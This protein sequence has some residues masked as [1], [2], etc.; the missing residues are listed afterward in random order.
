MTSSIVTITS[1]EQYLNLIKNSQEY[2]NITHLNFELSTETPESITKEFTF[3]AHEFHVN[4]DNTT[5]MTTTKTF[6]PKSEY[7]K[8]FSHTFNI[9]KNVIKPIDIVIP[10]NI[11]VLDLSNTNFLISNL[12]VSKLPQ[13]CT[14]IIL[15]NS[16]YKRIIGKNNSIMSIYIDNCKYIYEIEEINDHFLISY[17]DNAEMTRVIYHQKHLN[18]LQQ[19]KFYNDI[20]VLFLQSNNIKTFPNILPTNLNELYINST[21]I[22]SITTSFPQSLTTLYITQTPIT[23]LG[24]NIFNDNKD[25]IKE[26]VFDMNYLSE[27]PKVQ[28]SK[29]SHVIVKNT[30]I[31]D[32]DK[33]YLQNE[34]IKMEID[35]DITVN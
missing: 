31:K 26:I 15:N 1:L 27:F 23:S 21:L 30:N 10:K 4:N 24:K 5:K 29:L 14:T 7:N 28:F 18:I 11:E 17:N 13:S 25:T 3:N 19:Q 12:D 35:E 2:D 6:Y 16:N 34:E 33:S 22:E 9:G 20:N 32:I 8:F